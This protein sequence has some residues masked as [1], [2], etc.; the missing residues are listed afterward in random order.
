MC[1]CFTSLFYFITGQQPAHELPAVILAFCRVGYIGGDKRLGRCGAAYCVHFARFFCQHCWLEAVHVRRFVGVIGS[2]HHIRFAAVGVV[3][4]GGV[5]DENKVQVGGRSDVFQIIGVNGIAS[6]IGGFDPFA[7]FLLVRQAA[8]ILNFVSYQLQKHGFGVAVFIL[9]GVI[10]TDE[11]TARIGIGF[12]D[13][14]LNFQRLAI[15]DI[16]GQLVVDGN[17]VPV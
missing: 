1:F 4:D 7:L 9:R 16:G 6:V 10:H 12:F 15:G 3:G 13:D 14:R 11:L 17:L 2:F 5:F 8:G